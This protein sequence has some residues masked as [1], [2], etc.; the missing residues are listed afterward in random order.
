MNW[1]NKNWQR[2][3]PVVVLAA[4]MTLSFMGL[5][6]ASAQSGIVWQ[7]SYFDNANRQGTPV[8]TTS[9]NTLNFNWGEGSP[10][11]LPADNFSAIWT[12]DTYFNAGTYTF[13]LLADDYARITVDGTTVIDTFTSGRPDDQVTAD[14]NL[15]AGLHNVRVDYQELVGPAFISVNWSYVEPVGL[16]QLSVDR[17]VAE[18]YNNTSLTG[19]A[20]VSTI[21]NQ[22][23]ANWGAG[24]P[25]AAVS[26]DNFSASWRQQIATA[27]NYRVQVR[28]DDG[29]RVYIDNT[30]LINEWHAATG[31]TYQAA[32]NVDPGVTRLLTVEFFEQTGIAYIDFN[33]SRL[34]D[35]INGEWTA[36]FYD[37]TMLSGTPVLTTT[38]ASPTNNWG[39]GSPAPE[40]P[41]NNFSARFSTTTYLDAGTHRFQVQADDGVRLTVDGTVVID[42]YHAS[43]GQVYQ[44]D[45]T[46]N[47]GFHNIIIDYYEAG[48]L[49]FINYS[50]I[51]LDGAS[52]AEPVVAIAT[53]TAP[54]LNVRNAPST[55]SGDIIRR[56]SVGEAYG[57][58]GRT[59]DSEWWQIDLGDGVT[60]WVF[61]RF[62]SIDNSDVVPVT[63]EDN[64]PDYPPT[65]YVVAAQTNV[66]VRSQ[67][68]TGSALLAVMNPGETADLLGRNS[69]TTWWL[70]QYQ[71]ITGWVAAGLVEDVNGID[72]N[73][74]PIRS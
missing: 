57:V 69:S 32:F 1:Q 58:V 23:S 18:Y 38:V 27:G 16:P 9:E 13:T 49:A 64:V 43:S 2:R 54:R 62:V 71:G 41:V 67:P 5:S 52:S 66:N 12:T 59:N 56:V 30:L 14:I 72:L 39:S 51:L 73:Q 40:V 25:Y 50:R 15:T 48:G 36:Q 28:A 20:V 60:G 53:I 46:L 26:A 35:V 63:A 47:A 68:A 7:A 42:E 22:I 4:I 6:T 44:G 37:N 8:Y 21:E 31:Q 70:I 24:S 3:I 33:L 11:G 19:P 45:I 34:D 74:V 65:G 17:W 61:G 10:S 55:T 29:V